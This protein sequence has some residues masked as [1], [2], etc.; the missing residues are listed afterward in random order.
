MKKNLV[1]SGKWDDTVIMTYSEFGR[2]ASENASKG[3]DHGTAAPHFIIGGDIE[4]GIY[5]KHPSLSEVDKNGDLF[6]TTDFR[7]YYKQ[8]LKT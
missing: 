1:K 6:F 5:G 2:R 3:T 7:E 4:H 8:I